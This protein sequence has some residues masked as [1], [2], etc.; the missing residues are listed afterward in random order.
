MEFIFPSILA[1]EILVRQLCFE[2]AKISPS[3][4]QRLSSNGGSLATPTPNP[5]TGVGFLQ[6]DE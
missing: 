1:F 2:E 6:R 3:L 5:F 4:G